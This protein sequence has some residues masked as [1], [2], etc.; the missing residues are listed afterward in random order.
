MIDGTG[1]YFSVTLYMG[2]KITDQ[3]LRKL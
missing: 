3:R 2:K 1:L